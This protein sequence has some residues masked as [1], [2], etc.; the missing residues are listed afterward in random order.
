MARIT[1]TVCWTCSSK[2]RSPPAPTSTM[3]PTCTPPAL[4]ARTVS[5]MCSAVAGLRSQRSSAI[6]TTLHADVDLAQVESTHGA[7]LLRAHPDSGK[8][9]EEG[10]NAG[11]SRPR[12]LPPVGCALFGIGRRQFARLVHDAEKFFAPG[13][14]SPQGV[15]LSQED[16]SSQCE[17][18]TVVSHGSLHVGLELFDA[19][20][21]ELRVPVEATER[22]LVVSASVGGRQDQRRVLIG[23]QDRNVVDRSPETGPHPRGPRVHRMRPRRRAPRE[24][25]YR[26][27]KCGQKP[28]PLPTAEEPMRRP[29]AACV[30]P[31]RRCG[32]RF[33]NGSIHG[34]PDRRP[35]RANVRRSSSIRP[36]RP[37]RHWTL[38]CA[39]RN[40]RPERSKCKICCVGEMDI[41]TGRLEAHE[42]RLAESFQRDL[43]RRGVDR[44]GLRAFV[45]RRQV[46]VVRHPKQKA[47]VRESEA[48]TAG[49]FILQCLVREGK[50][51][52]VA[53]HAQGHLTEAPREPPREVQSP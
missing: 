6:G 9:I 33:R 1:L 36:D 37:R 20:R 5:S 32:R 31:S 19:L 41:Q 35:V 8:H 44:V 26:L 50:S 51:R 12:P 29:L 16:A 45:I 4:A 52:I 24:A 47:G 23:R 42:H 48:M 38:G 39:T 28:A 30:L 21:A 46:G 22:A 25:W 14:R 53:I 43:P 49:Q 2:N 34:A 3:T 17:S 18:V 40:N 27:P 11:E 10:R 7:E 15:G 13:P